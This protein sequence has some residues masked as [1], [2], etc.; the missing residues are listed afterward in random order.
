MELKG[1]PTWLALV[2]AERS[3]GLFLPLSLRFFCLLCFSFFLFFKH[4]ISYDYMSISVSYLSYLQTAQ[5]PQ[6]LRSRMMACLSF[7]SAWWLCPFLTLLP[8]SPHR[9]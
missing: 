1:D 2:L 8:H 7:S 6:S 5:L 4:L 9:H 3:G